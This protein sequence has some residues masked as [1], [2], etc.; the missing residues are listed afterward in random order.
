MALAECA[1]KSE[2]K[3]GCG[4]DLEDDLRDDALLFGESQSRI[5]MTCRRANLGRVL[6]LAAARG[7]PARAI[8]RVGGDAIA[9]S[10][11]GREILRVPVETGFRA[12][13]D[14]LPG[15][16]KVRT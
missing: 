9:V 8:G 6:E 4:I 16:F 12:W 15:F 11:K 10:R 2:G 7:V 1:F 13:K 14:S 5:V 3:T